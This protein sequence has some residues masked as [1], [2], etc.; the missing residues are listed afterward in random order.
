LEPIVDERMGST[1][2]PELTAWY[3][4]ADPGFW[5]LRS[6]AGRLWAMPN[7][8]GAWGH[9]LRF[10]IGWTPNVDQLPP[11]LARKVAHLLGVPG[12]GPLSPDDETMVG[13]ET[14]EERVV[15]EVVS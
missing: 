9:G 3:M 10:Q 5:V 6:P 13:W 12:Y 15:L 7:L 14:I 8:A 2:M 11:M 1:S 4:P